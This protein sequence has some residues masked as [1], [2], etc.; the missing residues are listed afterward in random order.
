MIAINLHEISDGLEGR[1][2]YH[3]R[4]KDFG[5][6]SHLAKQSEFE[7]ENGDVL[8]HKF[9][10]E[11]E[12]F[13]QV[14]YHL[15]ENEMVLLMEGKVIREHL[16]Q[17][18]V[19][20]VRINNKLPY[21]CAIART[22][23]TGGIQIDY[24]PTEFDNFAL[25]IDSEM[26]D[27]KSL[28]GLSQ[29][30]GNPAGDDTGGGEKIAPIPNAADLEHI[31]AESGSDTICVFNAEV[32]NINQGESIFQEHVTIFYLLRI[33]GGEIAPDIKKETLHRALDQAN[34]KISEILMKNTNIKVGDKITFNA[35]FKKDRK[36]GILL[37]NI[38][39]I[40]KSS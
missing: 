27:V 38:K 22:F 12:R 5:F 15:I 21:A 37:Q 31:A 34:V 23:Q 25:K 9:K 16:A 30:K 28:A 33:K 17:K 6:N 19:E 40:V 3:I 11:G 4:G 35:K 13:P 18:F 1:W 32:L 7:V 8:I 29:E 26:I 39:K 2:W 14:R 36:Q 24:R 10:D 20:Y